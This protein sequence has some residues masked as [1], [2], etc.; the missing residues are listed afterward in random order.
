M[1]CNKCLSTVLELI[2][3]LRIRKESHLSVNSTAG[4]E[5]AIGLRAC[6]TN[7]AHRLIENDENLFIIKP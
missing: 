6:P 4:S 1:T 3:F 2:F 5:I 7:L